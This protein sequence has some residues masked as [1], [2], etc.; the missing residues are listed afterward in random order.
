[1][2]RRL[3]QT[4]VFGSPDSDEPALCP[5]DAEE[6]DAFRREHTNESIW[7]GTSLPGGCGRQLMT[8][9]CIDKVSHF[10]HYKD[11]GAEH[12][13]GRRTRGKDGANHLFVKADLAA[14]ARTQGVSAV[15]DYPDPLGSGVL[16]RLEDA[17]VVL[18]HL[19]KA[20]P[21]PWTDETV[22]EVVLGPGVR[23]NPGVLA[24]RGYV[25]RIRFEDQPGGRR[26][27]QFGT[28]KPRVGTDWFGLDK[29]LLTAGGLTEA[30]HPAP[31]A[32]TSATARRTP[33][34]KQRTST[35]A[36][37]PATSQPPAA[38]QPEPVR[39]ALLRLSA[40]VRENQPSHV[41]VPCNRSRNS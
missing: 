18:V 7:C 20:R 1:M 16:I 3:I 15:F 35:P 9:R 8:R 10:A 30:G 28:E 14:W 4:A 34:S 36:T 37:P 31:A 39:R 12:Q 23:S 26:R 13:C 25:H 29:L 19:D 38:R 33:A 41:A 5:E 2:D 11:N 22:W 24:R 40:A 32:P 6:L 27:V 21:V 17:R